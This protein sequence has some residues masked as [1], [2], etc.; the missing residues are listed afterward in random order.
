MLEAVLAGA[1]A[2]YAVAIPVGAIAVL[3]I[4]TSVNGGLRTGAAAAA[5]AATADLLYAALAAFAG[6]WITSLIG[7]YER[8]LQIGGGVVLMAFGVRGLLA[9][10]SAR[11][12]VPAAA[13]H[14]AAG[15]P[16]RR[17]YAALL[18]LTVLNPATVVYFTALTVG[19]P[20]LGGLGERV[21]FAAAA[22]AASLSWQ[23]ALALFG[24][25]LGRGSRHR[26]RRATA[27]AGNGVIVVMGLLIL[28]QAL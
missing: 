1:L 3:I 27:A 21:A 12:T 9:L 2:G 28:A 16:L 22:G 25:A 6:L 23:L 24:A 20:F 26:L 17:T 8:E 10:R 7:P 11:E 14:A 5:G 15:R 13:A 18:V 19:L 4:H